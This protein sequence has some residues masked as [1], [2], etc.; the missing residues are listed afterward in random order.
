MARSLQDVGGNLIGGFATGLTQVLPAIT[1]RIDRFNEPAEVTTAGA[2]T[3][4][5][6]QLASGIILRDPNGA[7]RTDT[8]P[9][10]ALLIAGVANQYT[11]AQ[12]GDSIVWEVRNTGSAGELITLAAGVGVTLLGDIVFDAGATRV[13]KATRTGSAAVTV[14]SVNPL[15]APGQNNAVAS[16]IATAGAVTFTA[17]QWLGGYIARDPAGAGRA[18]LVPTA[19][20]MNT[21]NPSLAIGS[22][23]DTTL[24]NTA[25][26][27]ET[28][29][30]TANTGVTLI[31]AITVAQNEI[32][33]LRT[34][35]TAAAAFSVIKLG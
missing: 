5:A 9:T 19:A 10:A 3:Y 27:A 4:T 7:S 16:T 32:G 15:S 11:L 17:A 21:A 28:I 2:A 34:V 22:Y 33:V 29:T 1:R 12:D 14:L 31:G 23:F 13:L 30:L 24:N 35:K 20:Q 6:A 26:A 8:T 18:D 25:D